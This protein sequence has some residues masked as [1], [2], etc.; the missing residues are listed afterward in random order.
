MNPMRLMTANLLHHRG[1]TAAALRE[2]LDDVKPD[3]L[4]IQELTPPLTRPIEDRYPYHLLA[5]RPDAFGVSMAADRPAALAE[6]PMPYRPGVVAVLD[7]ERWP[8][9]GGPVE[10]FNIHLGNPIERWPWSMTRVRRGQV[11]A[12]EERLASTVPRRV[13]CGDFNA[14]PLWPAYRRLLRTHRDGVKEAAART[15]GRPARTWAPARSG[16]RLLRIDHVLVSGLRVISA[17]TVR[18]AGSDHLAVVTELADDEGL[19]AGA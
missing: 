13:I 10:V 8:E 7:P 9:F 3:I 6:L 11:E 18:L 17:E 5:P 12:L 2:A 1:A 16:P 15:G 4:A 19:Q 14:T